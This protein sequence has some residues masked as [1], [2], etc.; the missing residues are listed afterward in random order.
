MSVR[1]DTFTIRAYG[2]S[3]SNAGDEVLAKVWCEA[4]I[5]RFPDPAVT[6][7][8]A[9]MADLVDPGSEFGRKFRVIS[10]R[11]LNSDEI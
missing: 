10:F 2:E 1:S 3:W 9:Y 11:W 8:Q 5:Q 4:V 7:P 6:T